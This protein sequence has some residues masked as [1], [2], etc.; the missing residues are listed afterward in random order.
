MVLLTRFLFLTR[1][2]SYL[3][4]DAWNGPFNESNPLPSATSNMIVGYYDDTI[5]LLGGSDS[6]NTVAIY[7]INNDTISDFDT[8]AIPKDVE[9]INLFSQIG[10][11][12]Y[13]YYHRSSTVHF[14]LY[15]MA[16]YE[17]PGAAIPISYDYDIIEM[18]SDWHI[19]A[20]L[21]SSS[22]ITSYMDN[23]IVL[24]GVRYIDDSIT[25]GSSN[26]SVYN[27]TIKQ[28]SVG[29]EMT[30]HLS[31]VACIVE[32]DSGFLYIVNGE[33]VERIDVNDVLSN[34]G[35]K[36]DSC[37]RSSTTNFVNRLHFHKFS[38]NLTTS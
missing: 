21:D 10:S 7:D 29:T 35:L 30:S 8:L 34:T 27:L 37:E 14:I 1:I 20:H 17:S 12:L 19:P 38:H 11:T 5:F 24:G 25:S 3:C 18:D 32:E 23:L 31:N 9:G 33:Y 28:W 36:Y 4:T 16:S 6:L 22:C 26:V 15:D 13:I 2:V